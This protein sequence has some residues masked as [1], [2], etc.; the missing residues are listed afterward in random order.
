MD[1]AEEIDYSGPLDSRRL[2]PLERARHVIREALLGRGQDDE[3]WAALLSLEDFAELREV[4]ASLPVHWVAELPG[5]MLG[6]RY[7]AALVNWVA[8]Q[9]EDGRLVEEGWPLGAALCG[10]GS[11]RAFE[12]VWSLRSLHNYPTEPDESANGLVLQWLWSFPTDAFYF[13]A[14]HALAGDRRARLI[15][16]S[17]TECHPG[18]VWRFLIASFS[19]EEVASVLA[20]AKVEPTIKRSGILNV[21]DHAAASGTA[22]PKPMAETG[23]TNNLRLTAFRSRSRG[24]W[25]VVFEELQVH[26]VGCVRIQQYEMGSRPWP[27]AG[28]THRRFKSLDFPH[29]SSK[30]EPASPRAARRAFAEF[31]LESATQTTGEVWTPLHELRQMSDLGD[32]FEVV[33]VI[34]GLGAWHE[35]APSQHPAFQRLAEALAQGNFEVV[36]V[37]SNQSKNIMTKSSDPDAEGDANKVLRGRE[38]QFSPIAGRLCFRALPA[39]A[40]ERAEQVLRVFEDLG[41]P[42][43]GPDSERFSA[44]LHE[45]IRHGFT[46]HGSCEAAIEYSEA[47]HGGL[48]Y[49]IT[50]NSAALADRYE[51]WLPRGDQ[52]FGSYP[53]AMVL[54]VANQLGQRLKVLDI[55]AGNGRNALALARLGHQVD[56]VEMT[57]AF[58]IQIE[59]WAQRRS[60]DVTVQEVDFLKE[61]IRGARGPYHIA[62]L[63]QVTS[64]FGDSEDLDSVLAQLSAQLDPGGRIVLT[65]FITA[66][67][68]EPD[69][70]AREAARARWCTLYTPTEFAAAL[71]HA[72]LE[73]ELQTGVVE[74]ERT[75]LPA[76]AWPPTSWFVDWAEGR[77]VFPMQSPPLELLW[78]V[79]KRLS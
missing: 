73:V 76:L 62:I 13:V 66:E 56:A 30:A 42:F 57:E 19:P 24:D 23:S 5:E 27:E 70:V 18:T 16:R 74:F 50:V 10:S 28:P 4:M 39:L 21:L 77:N 63:S 79:L 48:N 75:H 59:K 44:E 67:G 35:I 41:Y 55:G 8:T 58:A 64:H 31:A 40:S 43:S 11:D 68:Y 15:L 6:A 45:A 7:G 49:E 52:M 69:E 26:S 78:F 47:S 38:R 2:M 51:A 37:D 12:V 3:V 22:W 34:T 25:H 17:L 14:S 20:S 65:A 53:D 32:P 36:D 61:P 71:Q 33:Q 9:I 54:H 1:L 29:V 46:L 72:G 60:L